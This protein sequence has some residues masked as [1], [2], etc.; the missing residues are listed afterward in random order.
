MGMYTTRCFDI[1]LY[2]INYS[3]I[4]NYIE[5]IYRYIAFKNTFDEDEDEDKLVNFEINCENF[6]CEIC[7][8][9]NE[10]TDSCIKLSCN[11]SFHT[12]CLQKH[13]KENGKI[14][15]LCRKTL[16]DKDNKLIKQNDYVINP[17]TKRK[18]KVNGKIYN[19]LINDGVDFD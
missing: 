18:I 9:T 12:S 3:L 15:S 11:H 4:I 17:F 2:S 14:C 16:I 1:N 7:F 5:N 10:T 6:E 8:D 13:I 19:Q